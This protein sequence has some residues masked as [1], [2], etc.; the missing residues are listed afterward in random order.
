M[1]DGD[2]Y[3]GGFF[4]D[5]GGVAEADY[6]ARWDGHSWAAL[7]SDGAGNGALKHGVAVLAPAGNTLLVGGYFEDAAGIQEA[8]YLARWNGS[9]WSALGSDGASDGALNSAV[10]GLAE[11]GSDLYVG[12]QFTDAAGFPQADYLARWNGSAWSA[13]GSSPGGYPALAYPVQSL[14]AVDTYL[15]VGGGFS[16]AAGISNAR[17]IARWNGSV[18]SAVGADG[19]AVLL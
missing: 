12:G 9:A 2:L 6:V 3:V 11:V 14:A 5:A 19:S 13:V 8:D 7:G 16:Y 4:T 10:R 17:N 1:W 15:Y 18:W